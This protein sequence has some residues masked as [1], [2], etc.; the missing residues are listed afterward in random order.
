MVGGGF[1][2]LFYCGLW[3]R[4]VASG[5]G[6]GS[7]RGGGEWVVVVVVVTCYIKQFDAL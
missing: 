7:G 3:E 6:R 4:R 1:V 2:L 5:C